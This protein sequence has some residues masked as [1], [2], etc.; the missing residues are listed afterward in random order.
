MVSPVTAYYA[1][2]DPTAVVGRRILAYGIDLLLVFGIAVAV[3]IPMFMD[4]SVVVPYGSVQCAESTVDEG[5]WQVNS[6]GNEG[7]IVD[8][9]AVNPTFCFHNGDETRYL[10]VEEE[11]AF[12][13]RVYSVLIG[14]QFVN[15]VLVQA[16]TGASVGKLITGLRVVREDGN[17]AGPGW[18]LLRWVLLFVDAF[19]CFL[20][21]AVM[22]FSTKGHRRLGDMAA[23][24]YVVARSSVGTPISITPTGQAGSAYS[25]GAWPPPSGAGTGWGT[26]A[27]EGS[28]NPWTPPGSMPPPGGPVTGPP[29]GMPPAPGLNPSGDGPTWD[30]A[31]ITYIQYDY[32]R[33][34]WLEWDD[35]LKIWVA[36]SR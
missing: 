30:P 33:G 7:I 16:L 34:E 13:A 9:S 35:G 15:L 10:P 21:G 32:D 12:T 19:C 26:N 25:G 20:P 11:N 27:G 2:Q 18:I 8:R 24:T 3:L 31:R 22:V 14:T 17:K 29:V 4:A 28:G 36:I 1:P 6:T 23:G 5:G